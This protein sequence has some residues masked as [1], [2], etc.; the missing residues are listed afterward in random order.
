MLIPNGVNFGAPKLNLTAPAVN[1]ICPTVFTEIEIYILRDS[2][3][4]DVPIDQ[5]YR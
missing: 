4:T 1:V 2:F 3:A 5:G